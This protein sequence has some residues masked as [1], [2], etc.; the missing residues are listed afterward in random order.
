MNQLFGTQHWLLDGDSSS[1]TKETKDVGWRATANKMAF[2][3]TLD[4][5][6]IKL[7]EL[8]TKDYTLVDAN[9]ININNNVKFDLVYSGISC[10]F[11]YPADT[12]RDLIEKHSHSN[13]KIIF[14]LRKKRVAQGDIN[15]KRQLLQGPKHVKCEIQFVSQS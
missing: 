12:Y 15:I 8:G 2:Y 3:N 9:N 7:Q 13:T 14:D 6:N 4:Q 1:N 5:L 11:H 10:G